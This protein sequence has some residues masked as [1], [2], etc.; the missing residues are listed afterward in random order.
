MKKAF[1]LTLILILLV[2]T[3]IIPA[4]AADISDIRN[5]PNY[6]IYCEETIYTVDLILDYSADWFYVDLQISDPFVLGYEIEITNYENLIEVYLDCIYDYGGTDFL[7][8]MSGETFEVDRHAAG[9]QITYYSDVPR[10]NVSIAI[11][12]YKFRLLNGNPSDSDAWQDGYLKG[13]QDWALALVTVLEEHGTNF[14][15][16]EGSDGDFEAILRFCFDKVLNKYSDQYYDLGYGRGYQKGKTE[17]FDSQVIVDS[18][19]KLAGE[20]SNTLIE[21]L[22]TKVLDYSLMEVIVA[23]IMIVLVLVG[24]KFIGAVL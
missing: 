21:I 11:R 2:S 24:V 4:A 16:Y 23:L 14:N 18:V 19:D 10:E 20:A 7:S 8:G 5:D 15:G 17:A 12:T 3:F 6:E 13:A 1:F 22:Q 9:V